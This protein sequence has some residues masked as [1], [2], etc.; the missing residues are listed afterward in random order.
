M[1]L[2]QIIAISK[3]QNH[4]KEWQIY[5]YKDNRI[6]LYSPQWE[7]DTSWGYD[8][9]IKNIAIDV[10]N[11]V[12]EWVDLYIEDGQEI[13]KTNGE[14][15]IDNQKAE[16]FRRLTSDVFANVGIISAKI[17]SEFLISKDS[18]DAG[19]KEFLKECFEDGLFLKEISDIIESDFQTP[20]EIS[21]LNDIDKQIIIRT[22]IE[23]YDFV[24]QFIKGLINSE[25]EEKQDYCIM[26]LNRVIMLESQ[27]FIKL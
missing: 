2:L 27:N 13:S 23:G 15:F 14:Y 1:E 8:S 26:F 3:K 16:P 18:D 25:F 19:E 9:K 20:I 10:D 7:L 22:K 17:Y 5:A 24:I 6:Y 11:E 21:E 12:L 4:N